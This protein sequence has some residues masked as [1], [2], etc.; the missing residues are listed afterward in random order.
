MSNA[1]VGPDSEWYYLREISRTLS[2]MINES[3]SSLEVTSG[4]IV[5]A[6]LGI[7]TLIVAIFS[8]RTARA[9]NELAR[10]AEERRIDR[11]DRSKRAEAGAAVQRWLERRVAIAAI[12]AKPDK[13][14]AA[15]RRS[16][17]EKLRLVGPSDNGLI[18]WID[19]QATE[20]GTLTATDRSAKS[21]ETYGRAAQ[22]VKDWIED[23]ELFDR[24]RTQQIRFR[25]LEN[26]LAEL[27]ADPLP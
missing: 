1:P 12:G 18:G 25:A 6:L 8:I 4:V 3:P 11:E 17:V 20:L 14:L 9:S 2:R 26:K 13:E 7:A 21:L 24:Y 16:A 10:Q 22:R 23:P 27:G 5:P 19:T 15:L